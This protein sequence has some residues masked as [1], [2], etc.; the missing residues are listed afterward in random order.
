MF[1]QSSVKRADYVERDDPS[2]PGDS[3]VAIM[4]TSPAAAPA[5]CAAHFSLGLWKREHNADIRSDLVRDRIVRAAGRG[6]GH[7]GA[8]LDVQ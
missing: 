5:S 6:A 4:T 3:I 8:A 2:W 1:A 7:R